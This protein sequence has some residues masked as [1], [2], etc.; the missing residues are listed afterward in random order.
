MACRP[1]PPG[2]RVSTLQ[3][4]TR[5]LVRRFKEHTGEGP[6][7]WIQKQ[8]IESGRQLLETTRLSLDDIVCEVGYTDVSSFRR[9]FK[10]HTGL[11]P[12]EYRHRF[13]AVSA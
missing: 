2:G 4:V 3:G 1:P 13:S 8:R 12:R 10:R 5:T 9:L 11:T 7:V 6:Q